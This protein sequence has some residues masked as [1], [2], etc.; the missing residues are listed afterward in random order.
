MVKKKKEKKTKGKKLIERIVK[1][2]SLLKPS[3][4]TVT[5]K[6]HNPVDYVSTFMKNEIEETKNAMFF[7]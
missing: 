7:K 3:Q 6:E 4:A 5:I 2:K 1:A